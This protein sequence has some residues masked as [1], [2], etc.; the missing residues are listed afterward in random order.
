MIKH[1]GYCDSAICQDD[2]NPNYK[3]EVLWLPGERICTKTPYTK[4]QRK[5]VAIQK[6]VVKGVFKNMD[7]AYTANDLETKSI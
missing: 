6:E 1:F 7:T 5:Q 4:F 2:P 3:D